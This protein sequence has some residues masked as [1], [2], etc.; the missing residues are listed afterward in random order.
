MISL[1]EDKAAVAQDS[2]LARAGSLDGA[3]NEAG[4]IHRAGVGAFFVAHG[5]CRRPVEGLDLPEDR[6]VP[7]WLWAEADAFVDDLE[8]GL[9]GEEEMGA[10]CRTR[11][12][13]DATA[14]SRT[15][16]RVSSRLS[17]FSVRWLRDCLHCP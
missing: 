1:D 17:R 10:P 14:I 8:V 6:S 5:L 4:S 3:A 7:I 15:P 16:Y 11:R 9:A 13:A 12:T 2:K